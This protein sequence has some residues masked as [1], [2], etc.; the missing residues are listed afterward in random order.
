M[1][2]NL[3][4]GTLDA[5]HKKTHLFFTTRRR[6]E[7]RRTHT[8]RNTAHI[9]KHTNNTSSAVH[10]VGL[11]PYRSSYRDQ[12]ILCGSRGA[13]H[14]LHHPRGASSRPESTRSTPGPS[15]VVVSA[16]SD[17]IGAV[18]GVP[19]SAD[20]RYVLGSCNTRRWFC[21]SVLAKCSTSRGHVRWMS[22]RC[23]PGSQL[24]AART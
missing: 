15:D 20:E 4:S 7:K 2:V 8:H 1:W 10:H 12:S 9:H 24:R 18:P 22:L 14:L 17:L 5:P 19:D 11:G 23:G 3:R 6:P 16:L 21:S 13:V